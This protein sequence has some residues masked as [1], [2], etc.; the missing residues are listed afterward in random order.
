[1]MEFD[2]QLEFED[3]QLESERTLGGG[4]AASRAS[5]GMGLLTPAQIERAS[6]DRDSREAL[7]L[8]E[9]SDFYVVSL[10]CSL[11]EAEGETIDRARFSVQLDAAEGGTTAWSLA[12]DRLSVERTV[13]TKVG[14]EIGLGL[15]DNVVLD[16]QLKFIANR[17]VKQEQQLDWLVGVG[18][19]QHDP[20]W[21]LR[22]L[23]G[24]SL[25]GDH[26]LKLVARTPKNAGLSLSCSLDAT[27]R[28]AGLGFFLT[29]AKHKTDESTD[30]YS[31][32]LAYTGPF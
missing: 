8:L 31:F 7:H 11:L 20:E 9:E 12:P 15:V 24:K 16:G 18:E 28:R 27:I 21:S 22:R 26:R 29:R 10:V 1:M 4:G 13:E 2:V 25:N 6:K 19:G 32:G 14:G 23:A 3:A 30:A 17:T 5:I